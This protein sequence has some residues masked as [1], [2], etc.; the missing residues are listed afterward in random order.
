[1][2]FMGLTIESRAI[3]LYWAKWSSKSSEYI[4]RPGPSRLGLEGLRNKIRNGSIP[5]P[6]S[7]HKYMHGWD[8]IWWPRA[9]FHSSMSF[10]C[11][12]SSSIL[13]CNSELLTCTV[14]RDW[15]FM[16]ACLPDSDEIYCKSPNYYRVFIH[17][18]IDIFYPAYSVSKLW[19]LWALLH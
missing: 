12:C 4:Q 13:T 7:I 11:T 6:A 17:A 8:H 3:Y 19:L 9:R 10:Q 1:M 16:N 15:V 5:C 14:R 2:S 18:S